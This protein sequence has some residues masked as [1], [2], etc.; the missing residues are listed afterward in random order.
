M[1]IERSDLTVGR[2]V[3]TAWHHIDC[4]GGINFY[5]NGGVVEAAGE[6]QCM[7]RCDGGRMRLIE[8]WE[9]VFDSEREAREWLADDIYRIAAEMNKAAAAM[10]AAQEV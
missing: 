9:R 5:V 1:V 6:G 8:F 10:V 4:N 2:R 3:V 7:M